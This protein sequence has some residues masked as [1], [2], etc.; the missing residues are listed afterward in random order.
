MAMTIN[1]NRQFD[2][3][4]SQ[5]EYCVLTATFATVMMKRVKV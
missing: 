4:A 2:T 3:K 1:A 5:T